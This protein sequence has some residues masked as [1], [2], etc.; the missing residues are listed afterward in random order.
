MLK[1]PAQEAGFEVGDRGRVYNTHMGNFSQGA[2]VELEYDDQTSA[3]LWKLIE[4]ECGYNRSEGCAPGAYALVSCVEKVNKEELW[5]VA[6]IDDSG[7]CIRSSI[8]NSKEEAKNAAERWVSISKHYKAHI[9]KFTDTCVY[10]AVKW[11]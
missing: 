11:V 5:F 6:V 3:P 1:T 9:G 8:E 4:G 2:L 10:N 7:V